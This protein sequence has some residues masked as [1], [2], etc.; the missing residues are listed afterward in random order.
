M[1]VTSFSQFAE[2]IPAWLHWLPEWL[3]QILFQCYRCFIEDARWKLLTEGLKITF[4]VTLGALALGVLIGLILAMIL[5]LIH[6]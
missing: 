3:K 1:T 4:I 2:T 5:S 6:I